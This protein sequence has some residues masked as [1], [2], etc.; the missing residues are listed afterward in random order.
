MRLFIVFCQT[1]TRPDRVKEILFVEPI[2]AALPFVFAIVSFSFIR[3]VSSAVLQYIFFRSFEA[4][5]FLLL[6][7]VK[8]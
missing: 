6:C 1:N 5:F 2:V 7:F 8:V 3:V 4:V